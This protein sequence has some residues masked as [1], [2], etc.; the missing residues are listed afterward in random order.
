MRN[1]LSGM[2]YCG[3]MPKR[4]MDFLCGVYEPIG[5]EVLPFFEDDCYGYYTVTEIARLLGVYSDTGKPHGHAISAIISKLD[6][7]A[8]HAIVIPY[9]MV[10][11]MLRYDWNVVERVINWIIENKK[12]VE[13]PHLDFVYH[14]Y[15]YDREQA[16]MLDDSIDGDLVID[17]DADEDEYGSE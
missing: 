5:V 15:Y 17:L 14:V 6:K 2:S 9:G 4:V 10:G 3:A 1:V 11:A 12:P 13:I 16:W 8:H 7:W